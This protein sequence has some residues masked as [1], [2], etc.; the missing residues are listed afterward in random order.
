MVKREV[1]MVTL[2][3][4]FRL[5]VTFICVSLPLFTG[6]GDFSQYPKYLHN[7]TLIDRDARDDANSNRY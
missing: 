1:S 6:D 5:A 7:I 4:F 2:L 3:L